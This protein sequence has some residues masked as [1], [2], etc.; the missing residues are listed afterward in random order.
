MVDVE[1]K[2]EVELGDALSEAV[3]FI[4]HVNDFAHTEPEDY[5]LPAMEERAELVRQALRFYGVP[6]TE[7]AA[8]C[9]V[10]ELHDTLHDTRVRLGIM[11][12]LVRDLLSL[13]PTKM[14]LRILKT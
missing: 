8:L 4:S 2:H 9:T 5:A 11:S 14:R 3:R 1:G 7:V 13:L 12:G 6:E 10:R